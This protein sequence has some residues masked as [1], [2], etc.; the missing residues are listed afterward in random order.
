MDRAYFIYQNQFKFLELESNDDKN[1]DQSYSS[2]ALKQ[3]S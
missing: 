2:I 3:E 1:Q